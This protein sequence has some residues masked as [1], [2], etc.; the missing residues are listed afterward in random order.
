[1]GAGVNII[2]GSLQGKILISQPLAQSTFFEQSV[3]LVCEHHKQGAWGLVI[4]KPSKHITVDKIAASVGITF[5]SD[6]PVYIGGPVETDGIHILHT[7]DCIMENTLW[8]TNSICSTSSISLLS[9]I[10]K[11][12]GPQ[13]WRLCMGVSAWQSGQL[14]GEMSGEHPWTPQ[15]RW[16]TQPCP[17][18]LFELPAEH[19]WKGQTHNAIESSVKNFFSD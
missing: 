5:E 2:Q 3:V 18:N 13:H 12:R 17:S 10:S 11:G 1:M 19:L 15:H 8:V 14:D 6:Q 9:E 4:N 7:P 16:L